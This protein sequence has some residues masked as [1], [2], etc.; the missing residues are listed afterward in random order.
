M[1]KTTKI[2]VL[3]AVLLLCLMLLL[4]G[5][6]VVAQETN[7]LTNPGFEN[8]YVTIPGNPDMEVAD[9][10][11]PWHNPRTEEM[12][13]FRNAQPEYRGTAPD[14]TRIR[15][16]ENAQVFFNKFLTHDGGVFQS[17]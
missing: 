9:G 3:K 13:N 10:W 1:V 7:L 6:S 5:L 15:N 16:G 2:H 12:E 17:I 8:P 4:N 14:T 11:T